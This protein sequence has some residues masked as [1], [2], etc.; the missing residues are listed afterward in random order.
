VPVASRAAGAPSGSA[1]ASS[2]DPHNILRGT[3]VLFLDHPR[4]PRGRE[5]L[6]EPP[7][8]VFNSI[9][10]WWHVAGVAVILGVLI[11]VPDHHASVD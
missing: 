8:R 7:R 2:D 1:K 11:L 6:H 5:H 4:D 10:V 9:S 3:F